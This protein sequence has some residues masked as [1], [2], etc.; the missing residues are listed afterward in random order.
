MGHIT[1]T[2]KLDAPGDGVYDGMEVELGFEMWAGI[3]YSFLSK[4]KPDLIDD[5]DIA[6]VCV[7]PWG[8][9]IDDTVDQKTAALAM[10]RFAEM[11]LG[12]IH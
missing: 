3:R 7:F 8:L 4:N 5:F 6:T 10:G 1:K 2:I 12:C 11:Y 9:F